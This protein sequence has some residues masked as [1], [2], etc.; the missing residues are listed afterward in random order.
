MIEKKK[1]KKKYRERMGGEE[2]VE[3][4]DGEIRSHRTEVEEIGDLR[5]KQ[6]REIRKGRG[7]V[8]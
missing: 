6:R 1:K 7:G 2:A 4:V 8:Q 5:R 3:I